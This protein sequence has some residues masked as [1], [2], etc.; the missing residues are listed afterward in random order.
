MN[1]RKKILLVDDDKDFLEGTRM[2]LEKNNFEVATAVSGKECLDKLNSFKPDLLILDIMMPE[3]SGF[4]V[5]KE[6]KNSLEYNK[7]PVLMLTALKQKL[8]QTS[9]SISQGLDLEAE[10]Y[11]D[12]PVKPE[13]LI[14][15]IN[16]L[17][18]KG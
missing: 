9:Y 18:R 4:E 3:K 12:K 10:D 17:L 2:I 11:I 5:C 16:N 8:S 1:T 14:S 6:I 13:E 15:R 7:I